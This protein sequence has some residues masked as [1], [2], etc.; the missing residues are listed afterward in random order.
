[1]RS[2]DNS[3]FALI[4]L[5]V[6]LVAFVSAP[7]WWVGTFFNQ[8]GT[9]HLYNA[10]LIGELVKGNSAI[11]SFAAINPHAIPNITGHW[12]L[13][14]LLPVFGATLTTKIALSSLFALFVASIVWLRWQT[15]GREGLSV[16]MLYAAALGL[17]WPWLLGFYNFVLAMS[18]LAFTLGLWWR[19][20]EDINL[21]RTACLLA[22]LIF[23]FFCHLIGFSLL[24][25]CLMLLVVTQYRRTG[26]RTTLLT[27]SVLA[28]SSLFVLNFL[29]L[30]LSDG[31]LLPQWRNFVGHSGLRSLVAQVSAADPF[32]LMTRRAIPF[33]ETRSG[34][35]AIFSPIVSIGSATAILIWLTFRNKGEK[36]GSMFG[37]I[38]TTAILFIIAIAGPDDFGSEH[39]GFLRE[40]LFLISL[41]CL[42]PVLR[43]SPG[44]YLSQIA[45]VLLAFVVIFQSAV[46][47]EYAPKAEAIGKHFLAAKEQIGN[48]GGL[49]SIVFAGG[50]WR[51]R[52]L[53]TA[54][55]SPIMGIG[56]NV[57][58]WDNY[59]L[60]FDFFPVIS[61]TGEQRD[62]VTAFRD[63]AN[64]NLDD[65]REDVVGKLKRL[66]ALL[67]SENHRF[68]VLLVW[69]EQAGFVSIRSKW[70][71]PDPYFV[72]G[73]LALY[74][75][76]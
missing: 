43:F 60:G 56:K 26:F 58:V 27:V 36:D 48:D 61:P 76:R 17:N 2:I 4:L 7:V 10:F 46:L 69:N 41:I 16:Y 8:D 18:A 14:A 75:H 35:F 54:N 66:D 53:P 13:A 29:S 3:N 42:L 34:L 55:L 1:M 70:F 33:V 67:E 73:P 31:G 52:P 39:G 30:G 28:I 74:R 22:L 40:R 49:G 12:L 64:Y 45:C 21:F 11:E 6:A 51:F 19:W 20:R 59:E 71:Y 9:P 23:T 24:A 38:V 37:W 68:K 50:E 63:A 65:P 47:W 44:G 5:F 72:S 57:E 32:A 62:F 25:V 15:G